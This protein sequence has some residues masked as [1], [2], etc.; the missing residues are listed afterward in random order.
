MRRFESEAFSGTVIEA[1]HGEGD[2]VMGNGIEAHL[3]REELANQAVHVLVCA[4][5]PGGIGMGEEEVCV[6]F[7]GDALVL[8]E[9]LAVVGRQRV[10]TGCK[11]RQQR[12][13]GFRNPVRCLERDVGDQRVTRRALVDRDQS[14]L[15]SG[16]DH[17]IGLP[18]TEAATFGHDGRTQI[19]GDLVGD[20]AA[21]LTTAI[22]FPPGLL[23]A[24]GAVQRTAGA[25]VGID[26]LVDAFVADGGLSIGFEIPG[27]LFRTPRLAK[28]DVNHGPGFGR[29]ARAVLT[30]PHAGL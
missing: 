21:P 4:S 18:V 16:A 3:F 19:D 22:T 26:S 7:F 23:A 15:V 29:N 13:D 5:F 25:L 9:L 1:M 17:Q 6:E 24:Q 8:G 20:G 12:D 11:R 30:G 10:D 2:L 14:L 27:D 28:F